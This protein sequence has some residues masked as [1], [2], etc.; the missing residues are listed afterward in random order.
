M[1]YVTCIVTKNSPLSLYLQKE[2]LDGHPIDEGI[3]KAMNDIN[4]YTNDNCQYSMDNLLGQI[5][6]EPPTVK[7]IKFRMKEFFFGNENNKIRLIQYL[8]AETTTAGIQTTVATR[9]TDSIIVSMAHQI[10]LNENEIACAL[11]CDLSEDGLDLDDDSLMDPDFEPDFEES[12]DESLEAEFDIDALVDTLNDDDRNSNFEVEVGPALSSSDI[13]ELIKRIS[14][15]TNLYVVQKD[16]N[17]TFRVSETEMRQFIGVVYMMSLIQLP[18]VT[19][20]WSSVLGTP[21]IQ[22][23]MPSNKFEK[24]RQYLHFND[25]TK[26]LHRTHPD[27]DRIF[28]IR[29][30]VDAL[31]ESYGKVPLEK[32]LC[33]DEQICSTKARNMLKRYNP[34]KPHKWGYKLYV[35]SGVSGFAYTIEIESGKENVVRPDEPDLG[36][37]SNVVVRLS[38][39][40]P[41]HQNYRLYFDNYFTSLH[42][43]EYLAKEGILGLGTIRRNRIPDCKLSSEKEIMKKDRG[44][45]EEYIADVNGVDVSTVVWKDNKLVTLASTFAGL[46]PISEV[47]RYDKKNSR[48]INIPRPNVVSEYNRHMGGVDL[49]DSIMG[50]YKIKLRSKRWQM[51]LFYH[52]LD[53][54]MANAWLFYKRVCKYK[55]IPNKTIMASAD[56]RLEIAETLCKMGV[57]TGLTIR[58]SIE[59]QILAKKHK[60]PAQHVPPQA[61]RQDQVGH[62]PQWAEKKS[63]V[64]SQSVLDLLIRR[65]RKQSL[66]DEYIAAALEDGADSDDGLDYDD[67]SL[68]DPDFIPEL[69]TFEDD[70]VALDID[71]IL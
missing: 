57:K 17:S 26:C 34:K 19:N 33:V 55:N 16:P 20:H 63:V 2:K 66:A 22:Q 24:I 36:A 8:T 51:R 60:G 37:S 68:A 10:H 1:Q 59:G 18:R 7:T 35:L 45:S 70:N 44:Y 43:L 3:S 31:N 38:R 52:F 46:N 27:S 47:R 40:I 56:F 65:D 61:V 41:R 42:L 39:M 4:D 71:M 62:W 14:E 6:G 28:K 15:E 12:I 5:T 11:Q 25:N 9:D 29:P 50:I 30:V 67:D 49:V 48:Y 53:L 64:S 69:E 13:P 54:T 21:V 23:T 32:Q 58:R